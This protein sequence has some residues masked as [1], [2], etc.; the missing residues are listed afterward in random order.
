MS[1]GSLRCSCA[2]SAVCTLLLSKKGAKTKD[3]RVPN[4]RHKT[5]HRIPN[6][7]RRA[8]TVGKMEIKKKGIKGFNDAVPDLSFV[9]FRSTVLQIALNNCLP[10]RVSTGPETNRNELFYAKR[11]QKHIAHLV[12]VFSWAFPVS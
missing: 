4:K 5:R 2:I 1:D 10:A 7:N 6:K 3:E 11:I 8:T 12:W 9:Q